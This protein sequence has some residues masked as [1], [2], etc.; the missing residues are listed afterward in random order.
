MSNQNAENKHDPVEQLQEKPGKDEFLIVGI[1]ASAGGIQALQEFFRNVPKDSDMAY[2]VI[3]H[4]SPDHDSQLASV[5]QRETKIPVTQVTK[6]VHIQPNHIYV[7]PPNQHLTMEDGFI[8]VSINLLMEERRAPVDIFFRTLG[9][10]HGPRAI[11]IILSGTGANGSM[12]LKRVKERGGACF[13]QSPRE[14]EF[15]EMPRNAIATELVDE[16]LLVKDIP[17]KIIS[18]KTSL[19]KVEITVEVEKRPEDQ[20]HALREIFTQL[21]LRTGHDFSNYKYPTLLRRI[22][23]RINIRNLPDLPAYAKFLQD[24]VDESIALLKDLLISVTNF[25][26]DSKPFETIE[27][28]VLP[29]VFKGK[30]SEDQVRIWVA[31]CAT[32]EEAYS[33][34]MLCMEKAMGAIDAP[35]VQIFATDIDESAIAHARE[36]LYTLNDTADV[37]PERIRRFFNKEGD[38]YRVRKEI[39]ETILFATHNFLKDPPFSHL[40]M[41]SCRNV[42]IYLNQIAQERIIETFHFALNPGGYLFLGTS[43]SVDGASDLYAAYNRENHIFQSRQVKPKAYPIPESTPSLNFSPFKKERV[44]QENENKILERISFGDLHQQLLEEYAS[45]SLV[46]N[47]EYEILH[48]TEKAG[49]YLQI[50]GGELS[51]NLLKLIKPELRLELRSALFQAMQRQSSVEAAGL[52]VNIA[53]KTETINVHVRPILRSGDMAK[54]FILILFEPATE[55]P[56]SEILLSPD[57][58]LAK[59]LEEELVKLKTQL[60][61]ANEQHD[62][63]AEE[64]KASNEELQ[65]MNEELRSAA[66]ELE[67][68]REELQS[69]NEELRTVN[70]ELKVKIEETS[71]ASNNLRN[72]INSTNIGTIFLDRSFRVGLFTPAAGN[73]FNLIPADF[74]RPL[75]DIT[76]RLEYK[77]LLNDAEAVLEKLNTVEKEVRTN[78][79]KIYLMR[80]TPYRTNEDRI[81]GVVITFVDISAR[82]IAEQQL[83]DNIDELIRFNSTMVR[84]ETRMIELKKQVNDL[85][86]RLNETL[87]YPLNFENENNT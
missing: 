19:G 34:A 80:I 63:Q 47:E 31:G 66:E 33:V 58:P 59:Q 62:F 17:A 12:G 2:V 68:S 50:G 9:D 1:G 43:E 36:G 65:A 76:S 84:R 56:N 7:V 40:D 15:N 30:T 11:A 13:V 20:Q 10:E 60:R 73:I 82:K 16:V 4:L 14:A 3:L 26:R 81:K 45:P 39:R 5:L 18:Y 57:E 55:G 24:N 25:F 74:D 77:G 37:S 72:L 44:S 23:R 41:I 48:L 69:I 6:R 61:A 22:E 67:T 83:K 42:M 29:F 54:G 86:A 52:K 35:K 49:K 87:P 79:D 71:L 32:G 38:S 85:S 75:S 21:R 51:Q 8:A 53:D 28:D 64:M 27:Q 70:Q 46:V 78:D